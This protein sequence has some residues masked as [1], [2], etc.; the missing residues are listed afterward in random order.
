MGFGM[1]PL[2]IS[3]P[4]LPVDA[5]PVMRGFNLFDIVLAC[6]CVEVGVM[7]LSTLL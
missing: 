4:R 5:G 2:R 7:G 1:L 3:S 6:M